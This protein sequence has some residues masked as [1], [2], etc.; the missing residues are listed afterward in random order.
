M[1]FH[2]DI[3]II[4][5][6][7]GALKVE[8][9][10]EKFHLNT[11]DFILVNSNVRHSWQALS[12][13]VLLGSLFVDSVMLREIFGGE[14]PLFLCNSSA[15]ESDSYKK[16]ALLHSPDIQLLSDD[17]RT[18]NPPEKQYLLSAFVSDHYGFYR[19]KRDEAV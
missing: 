11:D 1:H 10:A 14:L 4:Y 19:K 16:N 2:P 6:L 13:D 12:E 3:E 5:V 9:E 8:F 7:D 15:E 17:G 18:G